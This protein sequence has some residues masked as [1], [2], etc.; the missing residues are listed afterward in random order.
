MQ[1]DR[2]PMHGYWTKDFRRINPRFLPTGELNSLT[3]S[4]TLRQLVDVL[5]ANEIKLVLDIVCNHSSPDVNGSKG[6]VCCAG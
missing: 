4:S 6:V 3:N 5:H 1:Y 2:A